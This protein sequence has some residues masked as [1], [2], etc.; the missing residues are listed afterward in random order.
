ML[1]M[2]A[3]R[4]NSS[5]PIKVD[6]TEKMNITVYILAITALGAQLSQ[7]QGS[8]AKRPQVAPELTETQKK[9]V[10]KRSVELAGRLGVKL[11]SSDFVIDHIR[12]SNTV[13]ANSH[14]F[15]FSISPQTGGR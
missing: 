12:V 15:R 1:T 13:Y 11:K 2:V 4:P 3:S 6:R 14:R 8:I 5:P 7:A 9:L 10:I